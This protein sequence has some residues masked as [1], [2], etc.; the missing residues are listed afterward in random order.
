[1]ENIVLDVFESEFALGN[2]GEIF[3]PIVDGH[4]FDDRLF[5]QDAPPKGNRELAVA[6]SR[7]RA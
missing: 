7:R 1:M 3:D 4:L 6:A 5:L 2:G